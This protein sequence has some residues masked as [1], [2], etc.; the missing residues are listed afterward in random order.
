MLQTGA[1]ICLWTDDALLQPLHMEVG[2]VWEGMQ[3]V[4]KTWTLCGGP[5]T[6]TSA[7]SNLQ[8]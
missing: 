2:R 3:R 1:Y 4:W 7:W 8:V 6:N 5:E